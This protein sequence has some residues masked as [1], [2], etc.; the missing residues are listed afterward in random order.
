MGEAAYTYNKVLH[1]IYN[2]IVL[3]CTV[4]RIIHHC[5][6]WGHPID[7]DYNNIFSAIDQFTIK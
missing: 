5:A 2:N 7:V 6:V 3:N 1:I 4:S